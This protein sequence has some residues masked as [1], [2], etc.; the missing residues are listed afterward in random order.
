MKD[1]SLFPQVE[2]LINNPSISYYIPLLSRAVVIKIIRDVLEKERNIWRETKEKPIIEHLIQEIINRCS[3]SQKKQIHRVINATGVIIHTNLGRSPIAKEVWD[4]ASPL[5]THYASVEYD[6]VSGKRGVRNSHIS[7]LLSH[8]SG[9]KKG[10]VVNNNAAALYMILSH[11]AHNKEVI[12]SR[13]EL[14]QI[15]GGF[16]IPDIMKQSGAILVEVGTTNITT[17]DDYLEAIT[18]NTAI[19]LKVHRSNFAL[20]GFTKEVDITQLAHALP[21]HIMVV[22]DQGSGMPLN[23]YPGE[24]SVSHHIKMGAHLVSFSSD[25]VLSSVQSGCIVGKEELINSLITSPLYRVLRPGKTVLTLLEQTLIRHLNGEMGHALQRIGLSVETQKERASRILKSISSPHISIIE[26]HMTLGGGSSPDEF[27][28]DISICISSP[29]SEKTA[30]YLRNR[31][32][33]IISTIDSHKVLLHIST[34]F[35]E[36]IPLVTLA[37]QEIVENMLCT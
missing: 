37:L 7:E 15:G 11:F 6:S 26:S 24:M 25:K 10:M 23:G 3:L 22:S 8:I 12:V 19:V 29:S 27:S 16:R 17:V 18:D 33:P 9:A 32:I 4:S 36:D 13:S 5:N 35:E 28:D 30:A 1:N 21:P 31:D 14:V 34:L 2:Q 20:R